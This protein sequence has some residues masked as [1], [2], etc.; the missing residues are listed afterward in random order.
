MIHNITQIIT[1]KATAIIHRATLINDFLCTHIYVH[2]YRTHF[3]HSF[4]Q[5]SSDDKE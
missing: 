3:D 1:L 5:N 2:E 4:S